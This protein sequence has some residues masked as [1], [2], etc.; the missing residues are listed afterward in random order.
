MRAFEDAVTPTVTQKR[1]E[2]DEG[3]DENPPELQ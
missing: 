2:I 1:V 3:D